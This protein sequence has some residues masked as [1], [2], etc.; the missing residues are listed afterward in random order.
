MEGSWNRATPKSSIL[1]WDFLFFKPSSHW[2]TPIY[3]NLRRYWSIAV[4]IH[5]RVPSLSRP[6]WVGRVDVLWASYE[7]TLVGMQEAR[8]GFCPE[9][10]YEIQKTQN[11]HWIDQPWD[12]GWAFPVQVRN[13][14]VKK[15][16][17]KQRGAQRGSAPLV[18]PQRQGWKCF[19]WTSPKHFG[20]WDA[21][22][23]KTPCA[24]IP[25]SIF[26]DF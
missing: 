6:S 12:F 7:D 15:P 23:R 3:G 13:R 9:M 8:F 1:D 17:G 19:I 10:G 16:R 25:V 26:G 2:D 14:S 4:L 21:L 18:H 11:S 5:L 24:E 22:R 20:H